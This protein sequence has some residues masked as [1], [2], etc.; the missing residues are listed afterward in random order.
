MLDTLL[1]LP[2]IVAAC[3]QMIAHPEKFDL[4]DDHE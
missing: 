3:V 4:S 1:H 2:Q